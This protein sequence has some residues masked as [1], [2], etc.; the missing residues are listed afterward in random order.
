MEQITVNQAF[1]DLCE[2]RFF[3]KKIVLWHILPFEC[4]FPITDAKRVISVFQI[5]LLIL[6]LS[7]HFLLQA[8]QVKIM[9]LL[10]SDLVCVLHWLWMGVKQ[11]P[12]ITLGPIALSSFKLNRM[13]G[14]HSLLVFTT[15][16]DRDVGKH[17][18]STVTGWGLFGH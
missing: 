16:T 5:H 2:K 12:Q 13:A 17:T 15:L 11:F 4:K 9:W 3:P 6:S 1:T 7:N 10:S 18:H 14:W 8:H